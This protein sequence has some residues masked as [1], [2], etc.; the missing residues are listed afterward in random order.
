MPEFNLSFTTSPTTTA[1]SAMQD[2]AQVGGALG[3]SMIGMILMMPGLNFQE[4]VNPTRGSVT[5]GTPGGG[6]LPTDTSIPTLAL[7]LALVPF[8]LSRQGTAARAAAVAVF[9]P[10][11]RWVKLRLFNLCNDSR[12]SQIKGGLKVP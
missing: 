6:G 5:P 12:M 4:N 8:G 7:S 10:F 2:I 3:V 11:A 1:S 9:P